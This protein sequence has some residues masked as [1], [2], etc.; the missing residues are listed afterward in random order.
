MLVKFDCDSV[1]YVRYGGANRIVIKIRGNYTHVNTRKPRMIGN[2]ILTGKGMKVGR[3]IRRHWKNATLCVYHKDVFLGVVGINVRGYCH[4]SMVTLGD[5]L[6][7]PRFNENWNKAQSTLTDSIKNQIWPRI[8][9]LQKQASEELLEHICYLSQIGMDQEAMQVIQEYSFSPLI[10]CLAINKV[11]EGSGSAPGKDLFVI[12]N[13]QHKLALYKK[14]SVLRYDLN[15][16]MDVLIVEIPKSDGD[17]RKISISNIIDRVLQTQLSILLDAYYEGKYNESQ[18]GFRKGRNPLQAVGFLLKVIDKTDKNR[19]AIAL[20]DIQKCFDEISHDIVLKLFKV[21]PKWF[22]L[23]QRWLKT[24]LWSTEGKRLGVVQC[25]VAQGSVIGPMI[26]NVLLLNSIYSNSSSSKNLNIFSNL[27]RSFQPTLKG[28]RYKITRNIITYLDDII[29]TTNNSDELSSLIALVELSLSTVGLKLAQNKTQLIYYNQVGNRR[30]KFDYLGFSFLF[31]PFQK[32]CKGGILTRNDT[33]SERKNKN[34]ESTHLVYPSKKSYQSIKN[35][36]KKILALLKHITMVEVII[37]LN[38]VIK[39]WVN[40]FGWSL[41]YRRLSSLDHLLY[42]RFKRRLVDK[43]KLRGIRRVK[44]VVAK[45][46]LCKTSNSQEGFTLSPKNIKWHV[47]TKLAE[48]ANN[49]KRRSN[50]LFLVLATKLW[51]ILPITTCSIPPEL[52]SK[53]YYLSKASFQALHLQIL[54]LRS[55]PKQ[56]YKQQLFISQNGI[57]PECKLSLDLPQVSSDST[58]WKPGLDSLE[59]HHI[60]PIAEGAKKKK[61][62]HKSYNY[63]KNMVLLH[64]ECY[65]EIT[66]NRIT[67]ESLVLRDWLAEF[68]GSEKLL[69]K[70]IIKSNSE[71][72]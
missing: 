47:H 17:V 2:G 20:L 8:S 12:L 9:K 27:K 35:E 46:M 21:P 58:N 55:F 36:T 65:F 24:I 62:T 33:I 68:G 25:G 44:W 72:K 11:R 49:V 6:H 71:V 67:P 59:L 19:L 70:G 54:S 16:A 42:K 7:S 1:N 31:V 48:T 40:Y 14:T 30:I 63:I 69:S 53:P 28:S 61:E 32:V 4:R 57:C 13:N 50:Y 18:Y 56:N 43:Y 39:G 3:F 66:K 37:K 15:S 51:K 26:C 52:R 38:S 45:F 22:P 5:I 60:K 23:L 41:A 29:I 34:C 10:R 64:K